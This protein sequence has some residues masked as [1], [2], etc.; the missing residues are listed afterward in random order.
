[1]K[2]L[3]VDDHALF[4]DG[5][6]YV[7]QQLPEE[8]EILEAG[9]FPDGLKLAM[10]HPELDLALLDL[11]MPGSEGPVSIRFFHQRYPHIPVVVVSGEEGRGCMEKVMNYG[12]MGF[13]SKSSTAAVMLSALNLVLSG[14]VYIP[15]QLLRQYGEM[16][17]KE[18]DVADRRSLHTNE[19]GLTQR[20][21]EVLTHLAAGLSNK[22]IAEAIHLAEGTVKIHVAA[23]YQTLRVNNRMEA[24]RM[25]E[26]L[27]LVGAPHG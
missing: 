26:K 6:R 18:P 4:R 1:M 25:A 3:L 23:V 12:A 20:Q 13:I 24:V 21:M 22:E 8:V 7:L 17:G 9:N 27:G 5:M 11:N 15:P 10:Q 19:Y 14:G 2:I 16:A